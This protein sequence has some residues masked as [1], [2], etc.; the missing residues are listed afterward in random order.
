MYEENNQRELLMA[1]RS[2]DLPS[3]RSKEYWS[4]HER[5]ELKRL[6]ESGVGISE[7][8]LLLQRSENAVV[9]QLVAMGLLTP[10]GKQRAK[11]PKPPKCHCPGDRI[12]ECPYYGKGGYCC[13]N[14]T[15]TF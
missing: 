5:E 3:E 9:Q 12:S 10:P 7:I 6:Y 14:N 2:G 1:I 8:A 13:W 4:D 15:T 11:T